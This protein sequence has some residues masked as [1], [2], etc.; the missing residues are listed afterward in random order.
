ME[1]IS[2]ES[3]R[4]LCISILE[5]AVLDLAVWDDTIPMSPK[6]IKIRLGYMGDSVGFFSKNKT[7]ESPFTF[8]SCCE[9]GGMDYEEAKRLI[10]PKV[11]RAKD[12]LRERRAFN[13]KNRSQ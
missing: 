2:M 8:P 1:E 4:A 12:F 11:D 7:P 13:E 10:G 9:Y 6:T 3:L 5:R